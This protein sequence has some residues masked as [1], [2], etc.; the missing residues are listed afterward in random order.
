[1]KQG[2]ICSIKNVSA[3]SMRQ[4]AKYRRRGMLL[5]CPCTY[6]KEDKV[7][8]TDMLSS[9]LCLVSPLSN[10]KVVSIVCISDLSKD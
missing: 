9:K 1:M 4:Y 6:S 3:E 8:I 10:L 7:K 2:D 5:K